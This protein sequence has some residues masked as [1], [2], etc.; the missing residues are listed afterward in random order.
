MGC[1]RRVV[2][3]A[4][5]IAAVMHA[6]ASAET[7]VI[8]T[9]RVAITVET[10]AKGLDHPWAVEP[11][12]D[13]AL[14]VTERSGQ[15][16]LYRDGK[17]S[18]VRGLPPLW[19]KV[20]GGLLDVALSNDFEKDGIVFLTATQN[21]EGG[22]GT[23]VI[24]AKLAGNGGWLSHARTI[25]RSARPDPV[26]HNFGSRI[27]VAPDGSLFVTV[28]DQAREKLAQDRFDHRGTVIHINAD[29]SIPP[30]NPFRDGVDGLPEI[31]SYGHRNPQGITFDA[32][33]GT[34]YTVE[35]GAKGGDEINRPE[36]GKN[37]GWP[38]ISYGTDY[39]GSKIGIGTM[40][41]GMEQ[42][43]HYWDPSIAPSSI[44]VYR[45]DMFPE[46]NGNF[47]V[48]ALKFE[49][50][51]RLTRDAEGRIV[52]EERLLTDQFGRIRD[53]KEAPDGS[54][55]AVTD[56]DDGLLL[57]I[58]RHKTPAAGAEDP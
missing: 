39:D 38:V 43:V 20:Q 23:V 30:G 1:A 48:S 25:F 4:I 29:G 10:L 40:A 56:D 6:S 37:Y 11:L 16:K 58:A 34:L 57:R 8:Q 9:E 3:G 35:H 53:I 41:L 27:A 2:A 18:I 44:L 55:L 14:L 22:I 54:L 50:I 42:P 13:G 19:A 31:W 5:A 36:P 49:L 15:L 28:G 32:K 26:D 45:G 12:P 17:L 33:D 47:L 51:S 24:R 21:Y 46:W 7:A 52:G